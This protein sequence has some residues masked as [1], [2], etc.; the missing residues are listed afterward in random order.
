MYSVSQPFLTQVSCAHV[1]VMILGNSLIFHWLLCI[2]ACH[3]HVHWHHDSRS[4]CEDDSFDTHNFA[5]P[6]ES[7]D[8]VSETGFW[9]ASRRNPVTLSGSTLHQPRVLDRLWLWT[10]LV[11]INLWPAL[12]SLCSQGKTRGSQARFLAGYWCYTWVSLFIG[13]A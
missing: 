3:Q 13:N 11:H 6:L 10:C 7:D 9:V 8:D 5:T 1:V 4:I 2:A 12:C